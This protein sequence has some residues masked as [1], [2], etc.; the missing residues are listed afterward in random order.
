MDLYYNLFSTFHICGQNELGKNFFADGLRSCEE[1]PS[2]RILKITEYYVHIYNLLHFP[3]AIFHVYYFIN[4]IYTS[5]Q[6]SKVQNK[7][8]YYLT[9][10]SLY[11]DA[12]DSRLVM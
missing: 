3:F 7:L 9:N 2:T 11:R 12:L 4:V 8:M 5:T 1:T 10:S 6:R